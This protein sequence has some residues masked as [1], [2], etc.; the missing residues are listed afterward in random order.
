MEIIYNK[1][2]IGGYK[3]EVKKINNFIY[4][5]IYYYC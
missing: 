4:M 1:S 3:I 2:T 5:Y